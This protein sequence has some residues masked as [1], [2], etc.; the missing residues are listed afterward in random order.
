MFCLS[1]LFP[2]QSIL[3]SSGLLMS[4]VK[5]SPDMT[6]YSWGEI[7]RE[8]GILADAIWPWSWS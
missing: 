6:Q 8:S 1:G 4:S 3:G 7:M 5:S 2:T